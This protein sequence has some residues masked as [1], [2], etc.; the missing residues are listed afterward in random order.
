MHHHGIPEGNSS[1]HEAGVHCL[2][3]VEALLLVVVAG[4]PV[5]TVDPIMPPV[6]QFCC[7]RLQQLLR[8]VVAQRLV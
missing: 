2:S 5:D 3:I 1:H 8:Y 4:A 6:S 7:Y